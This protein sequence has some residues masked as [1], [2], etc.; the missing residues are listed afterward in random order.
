MDGHRPADQ[1]A[2][3]VG[4]DR[5]AQ[6]RADRAARPRRRGAARRRRRASASS[7][8]RSPTGWRCPT[9]RRRLRADPRRHRGPRYRR[10]DRAGRRP[11]RAAPL[12]AGQR[13][14]VDRP[15][16][17]RPVPP[18]CSSPSASRWRP[19]TSARTPRS[20]TGWSAR[21]WTGC[22]ARPATWTCH[23]PNASARLATLLAE[24]RPLAPPGHGA[25]GPAGHGPRRVRRDQRGR[26]PG[27]VRGHRELH[28][29]DD[30]R[31][32]RRA[33]R[34]RAR[35]GRR[36]GRPARR[37]GE[38]RLRPAPR[39]DRLAPQGRG[40]PRH[41][42]LGRALPA[43]RRAAR[44][45][46]GGDARLLRLEQGRRHVHVA[47]GD[48]PGDADAARRRRPPR[49]PPHACSTAGAA[50]R[51]AAAGRPPRRSCPSRAGRA[52]GLHQDH[53]AGRGHLRQVRHPFA[54]RPEPADDGRRGPRRP[55]SSTP[56]R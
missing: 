5:R 2:V 11:A 39:D 32:R 7:T 55:R 56:S 10:S 37:R 23:G 41:A 30:R 36:S 25:R 49:R 52:A 17:A 53:R 9:M 38:D 40:D 6:R 42:A 45:S 18:R 28:P 20:T 16:P 3:G 43:S 22:P 13:R 1:R 47:V 8:P 15:G 44:R 50:P 51:D 26:R 31:R 4:P 27:R 35:R 12:A 14:R 34:R 19:W 33:G 46:P 48:P 21:C 24:S 54:G 29:V